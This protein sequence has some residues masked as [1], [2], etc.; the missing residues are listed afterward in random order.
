MPEV[1]HISAAELARRLGV[2][3]PTVHEAIGNGRIEE[4]RRK[5]G[6][7]DVYE[8]PL[9]AE[10]WKQNAI[11]R[12][13]EKE[14]ERAAKLQER[15][16]KTEAEREAKRAKREA[17]K[18]VDKAKREALKEVDKAKRKA[19]REAE[20]EAIKAAKAVPPPEE[21]ITMPKTDGI[22]PRAKSQQVEAVYKARLVKLEYE[23]KSGALI[24]AKV[25]EQERFRAGRIIRDAMLNLPTRT[26]HALAAEL[27]AEVDP[28]VVSKVMEKEIRDLLTEVVEHNT[29]PAN[30][31]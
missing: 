4:A 24:A 13:A 23:E 15:I 27:G 17:I 31:A 3:R 9:V 1:E 2:S 8:W 30:A 18:E 14:A 29:A 28:L 22:P 5:Q 26:A 11:V 21:P 19:K 6:R 12:D 16:A 25:V 7:R 20:R 10:L